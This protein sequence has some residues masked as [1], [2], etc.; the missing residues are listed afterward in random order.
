MTLVSVSEAS[1]NLS[2]WIN[3]ASYGRE[4]IIVTSRG[5]AKAV[6]MGVEAFEAMIGVPD[7]TREPTR[8]IE[9]LRREFRQALAEAGYETRDQVVELV[10]QVKRELADERAAAR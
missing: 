5:R 6:L 8:S 4:C 10:R 7:Q 9:E 2:H 1:Q 3:Q